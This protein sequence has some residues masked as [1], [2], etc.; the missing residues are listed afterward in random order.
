MATPTVATSLEL[1]VTTPQ[2]PSIILIARPEL[3][4]SRPAARGAGIPPRYLDVSAE[5]KRPL[6]QPQT[7]KFPL[8]LAGPAGPLANL[9]ELAVL[10]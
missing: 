1:G 2:Y 4:A 6:S 3:S 7:V 5:R 9:A 8:C 10:E